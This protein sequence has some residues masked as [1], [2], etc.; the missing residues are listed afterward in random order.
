MKYTCLLYEDRF[1]GN[2][3]HTGDSRHWFMALHSTE[4]TWH[5]FIER[6][7]HSWA[8]V[9]PCDV[10]EALYRPY[11]VRM[12]K[13]VLFV[14]CSAWVSILNTLRERRLPV[15]RRLLPLRDVL[16]GEIF[17]L[18][19]SLDGSLPRLLQP[20]HAE[21]KQLA[22]SPRTASIAFQNATPV[23]DSLEAD[24]WKWV[25]PIIVFCLG[26]VQNTRR[27]E[28]VM[29]HTASPVWWLMLRLW[30]TPSLRTPA[31]WLFQI[32]AVGV[33]VLHS[34]LLSANSGLVKHVQ[35]VK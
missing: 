24:Y 29:V 32:L 35:C 26:N 15:R 33:F 19:L 27:V 23:A 20:M 14:R 2:C 34:F 13:I 10:R 5:C 7:I 22:P 12:T 1:P 25:N 31:R 6:Q 16:E 30:S 21:A 8:E 18:L 17:L 28:M 9:S 3:R 11:S 4:Q